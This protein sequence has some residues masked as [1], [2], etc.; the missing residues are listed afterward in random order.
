[1]QHLDRSSHKWDTSLVNE[2]T[3]QAPLKPLEWVASAREDLIAFPV[4]VRKALGYALYLAQVGEKAPAAKPLRGF[5]GASVVEIAN[6]HDG[7]TYWAVYTV[8]F[9]EAVFVLHAF[10]KKSKKGIATPKSE[11]DLIRQRLKAAAEIYQRHYRK[12]S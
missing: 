10:Q 6:D 3:E 5:G 1:M 2:I 11:F 12:K 4:P 7:S 9:A 8:N